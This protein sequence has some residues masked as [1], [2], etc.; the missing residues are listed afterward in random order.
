MNFQ[1]KLG[2]CGCPT[3]SLPPPCPEDLPLICIEENIP[4]M[5]E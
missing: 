2:P 4:K 5:G 3:Y 1:P